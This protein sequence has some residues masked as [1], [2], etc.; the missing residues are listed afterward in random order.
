[1][2]HFHS[3][4]WITKSNYCSESGN[5]KGR[6]AWCNIHERPAARCL[7]GAHDARH[8]LAV[9]VG[10][11]GQTA[12]AGHGVV[13]QLAVLVA[14]RALHVPLPFVHAH[15]L[16]GGGVG[17]PSSHEVA[18]VLGGPAG[19]TDVGGR[20]HDGGGA[21]GAAHGARGQQVVGDLGA[22]LV[23]GTV[24]LLHMFCRQ[25]GAGFIGGRLEKVGFC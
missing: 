25:L 18:V 17:G 16:R 6:V 24:Q 11:A 21:W 12:A 3:H 13:Q 14:L 19:L 15:E 9:D 2:Q 5:V 10:R 7:L 20:H 22:G 4:C 23:L 8:H 1:M